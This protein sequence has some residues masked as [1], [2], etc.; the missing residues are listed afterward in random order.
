[1][2]AIFFYGLFMDISLLQEKGFAPSEPVM[3]YVD[4]FGLR[5]G[6]RATLVKSE[7]ERAYGLIMTLTNKELLSLYGE[8]SV[9]DYVPE[10]IEVFD[11]NNMTVEVTVYN[12]PSALLSGRNKSYARSL[13]VVAKNAGLPDGYINEIERWAH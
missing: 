13:T 12:L 6:D 9:A 7:N 5:I 2:K 10:K 1:M 4:G 11:S 8:S 3:A